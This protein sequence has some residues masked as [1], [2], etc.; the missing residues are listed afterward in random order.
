MCLK[1]QLNN[2]EMKSLYAIA[3]ISLTATTILIS[4]A[5]AREISDRQPENLVE[6]DSLVLT[7]LNIAQKSPSAVCE[8]DLKGWN[9]TT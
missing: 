8:T 5:M 7:S 6:F 1:L 9:G 3:S 4:P 2:F